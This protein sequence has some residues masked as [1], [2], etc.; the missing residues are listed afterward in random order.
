MLLFFDPAAHCRHRNALASPNLIAICAANLSFR[1]SRLIDVTDY[2]AGCV[3][4][5][6]G[7]AGV[8]SPIQRQISLTITKTW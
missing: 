3:A 1:T 5:P 7:S 2:T 8:D 4:L 6:T